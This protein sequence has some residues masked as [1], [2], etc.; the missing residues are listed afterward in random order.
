MRTLAYG[1]DSSNN[2][3]VELIRQKNHRSQFLN[4]FYYNDIALK[5]GE[6]VKINH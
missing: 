3:Q 4:E 1:Q 2:H 6:G 5:L